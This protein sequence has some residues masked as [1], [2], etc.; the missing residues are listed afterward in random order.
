MIGR[1]EDDIRDMRINFIPTL[2]IVPK[3]DDKKLFE[4]AVF[5]YLFGHKYKLAPGYV[6][7]LFDIE[8]N[9]RKMATFCH[10]IIKKRTRLV[11]FGAR[12][13]VSY[14]ISAMRIIYPDIRIE[15]KDRMKKFISDASD[16]WDVRWIA[17]TCL[18]RCATIYIDDKMV[19]PNELS[20]ILAKVSGLK[21][22]TIVTRTYSTHKRHAYC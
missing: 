1:F 5:Y 17:L 14:Y 8:P 6:C 22:S 21:A 11:K 13:I 18:M 7:T 2:N 10:R 15:D 3:E 16:P 19:E 20:T 9:I 4:A 12:E